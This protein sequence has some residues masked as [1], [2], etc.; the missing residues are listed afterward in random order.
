MSTLK[1]R[2]LIAVLA[3]CMMLGLALAAGCAP[4]AAPTAPMA[5]A[6]AAAEQQAVT[7][8]PA[9]AEEPAAAQAP[10]PTLT[11]AA[12]MAPAATQAAVPSAAQP[13]NPPEVEAPVLEPAP[14]LRV[15][16][17]EWPE[18]LRLG[19][20]DVIRLS[21]I[22]SEDG[23]TARA[24]YDEH[25]VASQDIEVPR[26]EGYI[27]SAAAR[28]DG[29]AFDISP[30]GEQ[31]YI[32]SPDEIVTWR[33]SLSPRSPGRQRV[34]LL[35]MLRW[36][37]QAGQAGQTLETIAYDRSLEIQ[38]R[39]FLGLGKPEAAVF[40]FGGLALSGLLGVFAWR[41][42]AKKR[43]LM[44]DPNPN[45]TIEAG[46]GMSLNPDETRLIQAVFKRYQRLILVQEFLSGYSGARTFLARPLLAGGQADADTII[47]I[48]PQHDIQAEYEHYESYVK[49]RLPPITAR[50]QSSP[51]TVRA[52][53]HAA[54]RY[55]CISE[56]GRPPV[57]LRQALLAR[58]D[59]ILIRRLFDSFGP[60]WW[61]QRRPHTFR[62]AEEYDRLLPPHLVLEP[63]QGNR[64]RPSTSIQP[65]SDV[66]A[67]QIQV[68]QIV[69]V[70]SFGSYE[71]RVDGQSLTL[72]G[73]RNPGRG[74]LRLR[75]L[76]PIPPNNTPARVVALR[77][78][79]FRQYTAGLDLHGLP[80]PLPKLDGWLQE[81][82]AG[83]RS[84]IHGD[85]NLENILVGPGNLVWLIDFAQ[86]RE[87]HPL[88][89][90]AHLASEIISHVLTERYMDAKEYLAALRLGSDP[91]LGVLGE[92]AASCQFNS[93]DPREYHLALV[94]ACLGALKYQNLPQKAKQFLYL[95]A[96]YYG[97]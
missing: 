11:L 66:P 62:L 54:V 5:E 49:D 24:E 65:G 38:V 3:V 27:L 10:L 64:K 96:A 90:F 69:A 15:V 52:G 75:W 86:T 21:L 40:G 81:T 6:P 8:A 13:E 4:A 19:D 30:A 80:D 51:V 44:S 93:R 35:L 36:E 2:R 77:S 50:I 32:V 20:S 48:G 67:G 39:S 89:D 43:L 22:P 61:M 83:T 17:L 31:R 57:S 53:T 60:Y 23:Y 59:P 82:I 33:W 92:I 41:R 55:T 87:G 16:E 18:S 73:R 42:P 26:P 84:I 14:E 91:M 9:P 28:L 85:L 12:T 70:S 76:G 46:A 79:L 72:F 37:P 97:S 7:E 94:M 56:P 29:A 95:T 88:F 1:I 47:K 58:A 63:A 74:Q 34:S 68:G 45:L 78:D 71:T 25:T